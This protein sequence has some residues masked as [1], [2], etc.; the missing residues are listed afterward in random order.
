[1]YY[2]NTKLE[3]LFL[4]YNWKSS[5]FA[6]MYDNIK[7][8]G[9]GIF[10]EEL[11]GNVFVFMSIALFFITIF[12]RFL[13]DDYE[14]LYWFLWELKKRK[15]IKLSKTKFKKS[16]PFYRDTLEEYNPAILSYINDFILEK[17][18]DVI[19]ILLYLELKGVLNINLVEQTITKNTVPENIIQKLSESEK[20]IYEQ[21]ESNETI[22]IS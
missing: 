1:M 3:F 12:Y 14:S 17:D 10:M 11:I 22:N 16:I 18:I 20:Y 9:G 21:V 2:K 13:L 6:I 8:K 4:H 15:K 19:L 5:K 7:V